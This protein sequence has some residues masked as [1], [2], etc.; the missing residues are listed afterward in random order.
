MNYRKTNNRPSLKLIISFLLFFL[1]ATNFFVNSGNAN[2]KPENLYFL[3]SHYSV[4]L[5]P[6][7]VA[8]GDFN[9]DGVLDVVTANFVSEDVSVLLGNG[10]GSFQDPQSFSIGEELRSVDVGD[11]DGDRIL[12]LVV[13]PSGYNNVSVLVGNGDGSFQDPQSFPTGDYPRSVVVE[14]FNGDRILDLA[15]ANESSD[16]VSVL[17][18]NGD[19]SFQAPQF[20]PA[21][22]FPIEIAVGDFNNDGALDLVTTYC[23]PD[24]VAVLIQIVVYEVPVEINIYPKVLNLKSKGKRIISSIKLPEEYD[25]RDIVRDSLELFIP[26]CSGCEIIY[27]TCGFPLWKRYLAFFPRQDLIDEIEAMNLELPTKLDLIMTGE[28]NDGT[29]FEG[30]DTIRVIKWKKCN[31]RK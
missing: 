30:L 2:A 11:F 8:V 9:K 26:S 7:S 21:G 16:N 25:P 28:L 15:T 22:E 24:S 27:P 18:G 23:C 19:A 31:R 4:G 17:L 14:D 3:V 13:A 29:P 1:F 10:D 6:A 12:D 5:N 20:F